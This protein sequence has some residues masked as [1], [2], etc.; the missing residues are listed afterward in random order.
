M[1]NTIGAIELLEAGIKAENLRQKAI[2]ANVANLETPGFRRVDLK[3]KELLKKAIKSNDL[4]ELDQLKDQY[5]QPMNTPVGPNGNDVNL[6]AEVG[7]MVENS[8]KHK[9]YVRLLNKKYKQMETAL[10]TP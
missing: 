3:F 6:E 4:S 10:Q 2:A 9:T 1:S 5:Y 8:L 7:H